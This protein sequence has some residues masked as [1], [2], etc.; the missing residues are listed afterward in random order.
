LIDVGAGGKGKQAVL[1]LKK[2][3]KT[4]TDKSRRRHAKG[5]AMNASFCFFFQKEALALHFREA[6]ER[7][8][9]RTIGMT[10]CATAR[11]PRTSAGDHGRV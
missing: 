2:N 3:Q 5:E 6:A 1:F 4:F 7:L 11:A 9:S 10:A 8:S